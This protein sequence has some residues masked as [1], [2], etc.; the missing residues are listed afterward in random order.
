MQIDLIQGLT[1]SSGVS[2]DEVPVGTLEGIHKIRWEQSHLLGC[3]LP[4]EQV[5]FVLPPADRALG[6]GREL[7]SPERC[8]WRTLGSRAGPG[9]YSVR[10]QTWSTCGVQRM[11]SRVELVLL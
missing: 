3:R 1:L 9:L 4:P 5:L 10:R 11:Y 2:G 8:R 7:P 6:T